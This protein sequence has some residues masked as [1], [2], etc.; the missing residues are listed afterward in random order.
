MSA[1]EVVSREPNTRTEFTMK[2]W[3]PAVWD[4]LCN[5]DLIYNNVRR[6]GSSQPLR[7]FQE[8]LRR[9]RYVD[10]DVS[11][12]QHFIVPNHLICIVPGV[13]GA[14]GLLCFDDLPNILELT[15]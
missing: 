9:K 11:Y 6:A 4:L 7:E 8:R 2:L 3:S 10:N 1:V 12:V 5:D 14:L 15:F 13:C